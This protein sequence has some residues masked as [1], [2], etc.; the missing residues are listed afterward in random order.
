LDLVGH[1]ASAVLLIVGV[2]Q[3]PAGL[4]LLNKF[5]DN[6]PFSVCGLVDGAPHLQVLGRVSV[7]IL[8]RPLPCDNV[9]ASRRKSELV[10]VVGGQGGDDVSGGCVH[11]GH[12]LDRGEGKEAAI[13][14]VLAAPEVALG[15]LESRK[16][17]VYRR[18]IEDTNV[19]GSAVC[20]VSARLFEEVEDNRNALTG[21]LS[22]LSH[23]CQLSVSCRDSGSLTK[24]AMGG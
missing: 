16:I 6:L 17:L 18:S 2:L 4:G 14:G 13:R 15:A 5:A 10:N 21:K 22:R 9:C 19:L 11:H 12:V 7:L 8:G 20:R 23:D 3:V 24:Q 1:R